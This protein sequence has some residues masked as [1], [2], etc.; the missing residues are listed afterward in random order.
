MN[1]APPLAPG[2]PAGPGPVSLV[3]AT[4]NTLNLAAPGRVFYDNQEP[5]GADE[6]TRK[7][8]W[9]GAQLRRLNADL[10][11]VQEV[12]DESALRDAVRHAGLRY[13]TMLVPG[14]ENGAQGTPRVGV[15]TRLPLLASRS[16]AA[17]PPG[18]EVPVP[19]LPPHTRFERPVLHVEVE[20]SN[21]LKVHVITAHMKSKRP[22]FLQD[23]RG[24]PLED[25][26]DPRIQ[27][28]AALRSLIIRGSEA[29]ALRHIVLE[30]L[31]HT[32][33]PLV[34]LGDL[35]DGPMS[36]TSQLIA[37]THTVA[38]D[39]A[40]RDTALF[41]AGDVQSGLAMR[42][43]VSYSHVHQGWP[44]VLDQVWVSE[45][46]I[47]G[48]RFQTGEVVRVEHFNDHLH[49][50]RDRTRSDHGFVRTIFKLRP[51]APAA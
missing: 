5:Y 12:W 14:A 21:G 47:T 34:L 41:F 13:P 50:G 26:H 17:F 2:L 22:K 51:A 30:L 6:Y 23:E 48:S 32:R 9:L 33:E 36:V 40:A 24:E 4:A 43:D 25:R 42:R 19:E 29:A 38:F 8:L 10:V 44:E 27:A 35:N 46:F 16:I 31:E 11:A 3:L 20:A 15:V 1:N 39:R 18:F 28:R 7:T 45:E 49:E 37:A